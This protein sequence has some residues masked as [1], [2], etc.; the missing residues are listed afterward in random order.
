MIIAGIDEAGLGPVLGPLVL[1]AVAF[2]CDDSKAR[3]DL[4][5]LL[6][7]AVARK[8][9]RK[10]TGPIAIGDSKKLYNRKRKN[11]LAPLE[12]GV[13]GAFC[14]LTGQNPPANLADFYDIIAP[15]AR[16]DC[17]GYGW[18]EPQEHKLPV[19]A[20]RLDIKLSSDKLSETLKQSG[21]ELAGV[22]AIPVFVKQYNKLIAQIQNKST[23]VLGKTFEL[24][25][26]VA[27][28]WPGENVRLIVDRQGGRMRYLE[29]LSRIFPQRQI[30]ILEE[31]EKLS[32]YR[33]ADADRTIEIEF[34]VGGE[35]ASLATALASMFSK[36][37]REIC[38]MQFNNFWQ[39]RIPGLADTAGYY[40]DGN[41]FFDEICDEMSLLDIPE[42]S[43]YRCR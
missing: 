14:S 15:N 11:G 2:R 26:C 38:M 37:I 28:S 24:V 8:P 1:S 3:A 25:S 39:A 32:A 41:R 12:R 20:G 27:T 35:S 40:V 10:G 5:E 7:G 29:P 17:S 33:I 23:A 16:A 42:D 9:A 43:I 13:L 30:K 19:H 31:S 4:W 6:E 36:Y 22:R 18:Y 34:V 21:I